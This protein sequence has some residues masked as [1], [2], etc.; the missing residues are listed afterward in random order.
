MQ[1]I[2]KFLPV[3]L[4]S[5]FYSTS[6]L[7]E[8]EVSSSERNSIGTNSL[9]ETAASI[10]VKRASS[11]MLFCFSKNLT[12]LTLYRKNTELTQTI[13]LQGEQDEYNWPVGEEKIS[14]PWA[15]SDIK[16]N[17]R[18]LIILKDADIPDNEDELNLHFHE[19]PAELSHAEKSIWMKRKQ[20]DNQS[21]DDFLQVD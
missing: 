3:I 8:D 6:A 14:W 4:A 20:C 11:D 13:S 15:M 18:Y 16:D 21:N 1:F 19:I 2:K 12:E 17:S 9:L 5:A 7:S 10:V